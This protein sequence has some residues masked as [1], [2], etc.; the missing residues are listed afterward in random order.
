MVRHAAALALALVCCRVGRASY[1]L[2][3]TS[4]RTIASLTPELCVEPDLELQ[5]MKPTNL[6]QYIRTPLESVRSQLAADTRGGHLQMV[7]SRR[8]L[9][10]VGPSAQ[11]ACMQGRDS[12]ESPHTLGVPVAQ[13]GGLLPTL[14]RIYSAPLILHQV[15]LDEGL[16]NLG[17]TRRLERAMH[18]LVT[19][20]LAAPASR[21]ST[22]P[23]SR[24][25][26]ALWL[27]RPANHDGGAGRQRDLRHRHLQAGEH[28]GAP[29]VLLG[30]ARLPARAAQVHTRQPPALA[31]SLQG[32]TI[33]GEASTQIQ[34]QR[35]GGRAA[36]APVG[37]PG[38]ALVCS[39]CTRTQAAQQ[40]GPRRHLGLHLALRA[41]HAAPGRGP[42]LPRVHLQ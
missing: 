5:R 33:R 22:P 13:V 32:Q 39:P 14:E 28:L 4:S 21:P 8:S 41:G 40:G 18:K 3:H 17:D 29:G 26:G 19:G 36:V 35:W 6:T 25:I 31:A 30:A 2:T 1:L 9:S 37:H 24:R 38:P 10:A 20:T 34:G 23:S 42:G 11:G 16:S 12:G 7:K 27:R 15:M